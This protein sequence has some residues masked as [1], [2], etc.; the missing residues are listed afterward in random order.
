MPT[1]RHPNRSEPTPKTTTPNNPESSH[2]PGS[3]DQTGAAHLARELLHVDRRLVSLL[4]YLRR[5]V[6]SPFGL[7]DISHP[8]RW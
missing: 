2:R 3:P 1:E 7:P 8:G 6:D 5:V 4:E